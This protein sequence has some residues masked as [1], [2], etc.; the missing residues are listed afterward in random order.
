M[1]AF[2]IYD[3]DKNEVFVCRDR[4]G[5]KPLYYYKNDNIVI[6]SSEIKTILD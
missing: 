1:F 5:V 6:F 4:F 2:I 3:I